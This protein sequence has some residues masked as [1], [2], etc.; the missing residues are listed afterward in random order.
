MS[1]P[2]VFAVGLGV[3]AIEQARFVCTPKE[4]D[5]GV[6]CAQKLLSRQKM[7]VQRDVDYDS[8]ASSRSRAISC[9]FLLL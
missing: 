7:M 2:S 1:G 8:A 6:S 3:V 5:F 9:Y 4:E